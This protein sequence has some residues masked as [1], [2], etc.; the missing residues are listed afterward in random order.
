MTHS[1]T[2]ITANNM[3]KLLYIFLLSPL[4]LTAQVQV[5][6]GPDANSFITSPLDVDSLFYWFAADMAVFDSVGNVAT[7]WQGVGEWQDLSGNG[8]HVT[9]A[10]NG[11]RPTYRASEGPNGR[12]ALVFDGSNDLLVS[13]AHFWES[14]DVSIFYVM[15]FANA[16]R[17][18]VE[19]VFARTDGTNA[20]FLIQGRQAAVSYNMWLVKYSSGANRVDERDSPKSASWELHAWQSPPS[21]TTMHI[22]GT[23]TS[24]S[25]S[26]TGSGDGTIE[27]KSVPIAFG[28]QNVPTPTIFLQGSISEFIVYS[29]AVTTAERQAIENYLNKKY[30]IY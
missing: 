19:P 3:K 24:I 28:G 20:Q 16:T 22:N 10:T 12:P 26:T 27:D 18:A 6:F 14:D 13:A 15:K 9:Q 25:R 4:F 29:R 2:R 23:S 11:A 5:F 1:Q 17:N 7:D 21:A 30:N 8:H